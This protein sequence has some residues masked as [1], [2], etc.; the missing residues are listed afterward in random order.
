MEKRRFAGSEADPLLDGRTRSVRQ[1]NIWRVEFPS[2]RNREHHGSP[3]AKQSRLPL[4]T[5]VPSLAGEGR[6]RQMARAHCLNRKSS[7]KLNLSQSEVGRLLEDVACKEGVHGGGGDLRSRSQRL[8]HIDWGFGIMDTRLE[9]EWA[10]H[11]ET[12]S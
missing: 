1:W 7:P 12:D 4:R 9:A 2:A 6:S 11:C 8:G 10:A 5:V 3:S